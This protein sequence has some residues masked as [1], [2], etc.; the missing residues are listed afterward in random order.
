M[1]LVSAD[2]LLPTDLNEWINNKCSV[3][4]IPHLN[5]SNS[6][7][8]SHSSKKRE[9]QEKLQMQTI[10]CNIVTHCFKNQVCK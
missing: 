6:C 4:T 1:D 10:K 8:R 3:R 5:I 7:T 9:L 2:F